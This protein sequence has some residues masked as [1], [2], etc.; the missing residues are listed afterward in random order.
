MT[1]P[2]N[3][4][5]SVHRGGAWQGE[6]LSAN[7]LPCFMEIFSMHNKCLY[8]CSTLLC[9]IIQFFLFHLKAFV[10]MFFV[11][12]RSHLRLYI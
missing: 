4:T 5:D 8:Q 12:S 6:G 10:C 2:G 11:H 3:Y 9:Y 1:N 7:G